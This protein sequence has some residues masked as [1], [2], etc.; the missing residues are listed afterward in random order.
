MD[1]A[2]ST[3]CN[4]NISR[5]DWDYLWGQTSAI[6]RR[7]SWLEEYEDCTAR[8]ADIDAFAIQH[9]KLKKLLELI[10]ESL[11]VA[12]YDS[13]GNLRPDEEILADLAVAFMKINISIDDV[14]GE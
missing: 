11:G 6:D 9:Y 4:L 2:N 13:Y 8:K 7:V 5:G 12:P 14:L 3:S 1:T 10:Y